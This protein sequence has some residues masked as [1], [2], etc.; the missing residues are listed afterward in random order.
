MV[1]SET[2]SALYPAL[3][4]H[5]RRARGLSQL[6]LSVAADVSARHVSFL[7]TGRA[8]PSR[9]MVLRL[10]AALD[11]PLRDT[12]DLLRAAGHDEA[13]E[14]PSLDE[15]LAGPLGQ[16][17]DRM[18]AGHEPYPMLVVDRRY[19]LIRANQGTQR[20]MELFIEDPAAVTPPINLFRAL[21][22]PRLLRPS[23]QDF[24]Q[25]S[26]VLMLRLHR[27]ILHDPRNRALRDL[28]EE[29]QPLI[30]FR[31]SEVDLGRKSE[32]TFTF[33]LCRADHR[34]S[35]FGTV[36]MFNAPQNVTVEE[37]RIESLFPQDDATEAF[38]KRVAGHHEGT[39]RV[40]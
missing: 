8:E 3:L 34:V 35:L 5:W 12:N 10:A 39:P 23:V 25:I 21:V 37:L 19:D 31:T 22:D 40:P 17:V 26:E 11:V 27:E 32:P 2:R 13:L 9:G 33:T 1:P 28:Q 16:A 29:L 36:T 38:L 24:E 4:R 15:A 7:E 18:L 14:E 20:L 6:D 30:G